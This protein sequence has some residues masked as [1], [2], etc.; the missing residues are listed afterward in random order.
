VPATYCAE[1]QLPLTTELLEELGLTLDATL[2][3]LTLDATLLTTDVLLA[4]DA[5]LLAPLQAPSEVHSWY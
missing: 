3:D 2:E 1:A 4:L 5:A